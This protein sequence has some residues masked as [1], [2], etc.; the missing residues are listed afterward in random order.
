MFAIQ[1]KTPAWMGVDVHVDGAGCQHATLYRTVYPFRTYNIPNT[2][3]P[4]PCFTYHRLLAV[5]QG[6]W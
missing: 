1:C 4:I 5:R 6:F 3:P 2:Y